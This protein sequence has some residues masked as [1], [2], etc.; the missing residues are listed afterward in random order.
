MQ[1]DWYDRI[2]CFSLIP[3]FLFWRRTYMTG[4][5]LK[6]CCGQ[7][8]DRRAVPWPSNLRSLGQMAVPGIHHF[9]ALVS[10]SKQHFHRLGLKRAQNMICPP[11][12]ITCPP[13]SS[14]NCAHGSA[15]PL[16]RPPPLTKIPGSAP[17]EE[18]V[19]R[20]L[21]G[22]HAWVRNQNE[23]NAIATASCKWERL[24]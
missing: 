5:F 10:L 3:T 9:F 23:V 11:W 16:S 24:T 4:I 8:R 15:P 14:P 18:E 13:K 12:V 21:G 2:L 7:G 1:R 6:L 19:A 17:E 22:F 20:P